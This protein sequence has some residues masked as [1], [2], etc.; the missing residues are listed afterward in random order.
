MGFR[1]IYMH[2]EIADSLKGK[3]ILLVNTG[4]HKKRFIIQ[5]L[6]KLGLVVVVLNKERNW[7]APYVDHWIVADTFNHAEAVK[8][9][10]LF[11]KA[12]PDVHIDGV[13]TFWEDDVL[14]TSKIVDKFNFIGIPYDIARQTRNKYLFRE[15]CIAN[16]IRAPRHH[17]L[18]E[19]GDIDFV[20]DNFQFP[21]VVKPAYGASSAY[22]IKVYN[23]EDLINTYKFLKHNINIELETALS[24]GLDIFIEEYIDGDEVDVDIL[25][26]NGKIKCCIVSDNFNKD[27]GVFFVDSG[28][29][30]PTTLP[31]EHIQALSDMAEETL[32][33][34]GIQNGCIHYEAK[35]TKNGPCPLEVNLRMGG[36][37]IYSYIKSAWGIDLIDYAVRI[38]I[39]QF[40]KIKDVKPR[41]YIIGWDLHPDYSGLLVELSVDDSLRKEKYFEEINLYKEVGDPVLLPPEGQ[42]HIGWLTVSG[43]NFLDAQDNLKKALAKVNFKVVKFDPDSFMGKTLRKDRFSAAVLNKDVLLRAARLEK[44]KRILHGGQ[45][46]LHIGIAGNMAEETNG[47]DPIGKTVVKVLRE[48]G[49]RVTFFDFNNLVKAFN[50]LRR[51]DVDLVFNMCKKINNSTDLEPAAAAILESLQIPYTGSDSAVLSLCRDKIKV[52]KLLTYHDI[53]TPKWDYA[54]ELGDE[55]RDDLRFPLIVKP[56]TSDNSIGITNDSVVTDRK[57]MEM[58]LRRII[59]DYGKPA[60]VEEYVDGDEYDVSILGSNNDDI[61]VLPLSRSLF[62]DLPKD[63]WH[64]YTYAAK[65][66]VDPVYQKIEIQHPPKNIGRKLESLITEIA[67]DTYSILDCRDYGRVEIRVDSNDNPYVLELDPNPSLDISYARLPQVA[68]LVGMDFGD[69][70]EEIIYFAIQRFRQTHY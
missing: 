57:Q 31:A 10:E 70:L 68:Q 42:E 1:F 65:K 12:N 63:Y 46:G 37:Y 4:S 3:T 36:D 51:S 53:P 47:H 61:R 59:I 30:T 6:K 38:A 69:L 40:F 54:Y 32:E 34:L 44:V 60:I 35:S 2:V 39:G 19:E 67:L 29:A 18:K 56:G 23:R 14:L 22:V 33:K 25:V 16:S 9:V 48:R 17:L 58:Q 62:K 8:A 13:V 27:K 41:R 49:Y 52:K 50:D 28:Q 20:C 11:I 7:A 24:D 45:K 21:L 43:D 64:I 15:F 55:I 5:R 66:G 26:Q